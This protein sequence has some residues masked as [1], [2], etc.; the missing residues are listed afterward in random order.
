MVFASSFASHGKMDAA[1][2]TIDDLKRQKGHD[3]RL[4]LD[5]SSH[6]VRWNRFKAQQVVPV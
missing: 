4:E 1:P 5:L 2:R 3:F 6:G